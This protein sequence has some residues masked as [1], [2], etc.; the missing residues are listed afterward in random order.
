MSLTTATILCTAFG[1]VFS[2][3]LD[4]KMYGGWLWEM[5]R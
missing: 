5:F 4:R 2:V 3:L 1:A